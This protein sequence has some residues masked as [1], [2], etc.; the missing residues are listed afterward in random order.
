MSNIFY[1]SVDDE[2]NFIKSMLRNQRN[3]LLNESDKY[4]LIDYP[5]TSDNLVLIKD[6]RRELRDFT[7]NDY[8]LPDFPF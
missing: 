5:I 3:Q 1:I 7:N 4:V 2:N 6:Y 8:I